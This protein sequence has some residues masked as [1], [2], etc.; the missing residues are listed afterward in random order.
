MKTLVST[1]SPLVALISAII[2]FFFC[3]QNQET[4]IHSSGGPRG[5][6]EARSNPSPPPPPVFKYP[7]KK[8]L[9]GLTE[10]NL[11]H[12]HGILNKSKAKLHTFIHM[13]PLSKNPGSSPAF[14]HC[15]NAL[16]FFFREWI[17]CEIAVTEEWL[18]WSLQK[19]QN[20]KAF[21]IICSSWEFSRDY[22]FY[23]LFCKK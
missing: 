1:Y 3:K 23:R 9:F 10:T 19:P 4:V 22:A 8:K 13:N 21:T 12:F 14:M 6:Q 7:M 16:W 17:W 20:P 5:G 18:L 15:S 11:F 2:T